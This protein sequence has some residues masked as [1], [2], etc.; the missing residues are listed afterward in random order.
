MGLHGDY[1]GRGAW[2]IWGFEAYPDQ[3]GLVGTIR[4]LLGTT[5]AEGP[6]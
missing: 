5:G 3:S 6:S 4:S 2:P 1:I